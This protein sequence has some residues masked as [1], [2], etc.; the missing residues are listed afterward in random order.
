MRRFRID[1]ANRAE[2]VRAAAESLLAGGVVVFPTD[3]VYGIAA[4]PGFP[5]ALERIYAIKRRRPE[6]PVAFLASD[7][8]APER[9]GATMPPPA[10]A[11][12]EKGWPGALTLVLDCPG[13]M[14]EGFRVPDSALAR[15]IIAACGGLLRVTSANFSGE[16]ATAE[17]T[18]EYDA[19][20]DLCDVVIDDGRCAGGVPSEVVKVTAGGE[21]TIL[22]RKA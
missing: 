7:V 5:E 8:S 12:A 20:C 19:F 16:P 4:H 11:L 15:E 22:R 10:R 13:G 17:L 9:F 21:V 2:A 18:P 3:T 6:K 1:G 14:A